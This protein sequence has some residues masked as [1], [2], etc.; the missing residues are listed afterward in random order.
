MYTVYVTDSASSERSRPWT[1]AFTLLMATVMGVAIFSRAGLGIFSRFLIEDFGISRTQLGTLA[2]V[3]ALT[4]AFASPFMGQIADRVGGKV[5]AIAVFA[6]SA[7][8][9]VGMALSPLFIVLIA[10]GMIT[11]IAQ[12]AANPST[13]KLIRHFIEPGRR[14][15]VTGFKQSGVQFA[16]FI[17]GLV[18]PTLALAYGWRVA[19]ALVAL[20]PLVGIV[21]ISIIIPRDAPATAAAGGEVKEKVPIPTSVRWIASQ[22]VLVGFGAGAL[23]TYLALY[24]EDEVGMHVTRAGFLVSVYGLAGLISRL[25]LPVVS[26]RGRHRAHQMLLVAAA[27]IVGTLLIWK[28]AEV[29]VALVWIGAAIAGTQVAWTALAML[30]VITRVPQLAAGRA[31]GFVT[32][33]FGVGLAMGPPVFGFIVDSAGYDQAFA[34]LIAVMIGAVGLMMLWLR[35]ETKTPQLVD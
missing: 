35:S 12:G 29:S 26:E 1:I 30:D 23:L 5:M 20:V 4:G 14:G 13:N 19:L 22:G 8:G 2:A 18:V 24:A 15:F 16:L 28:G 10:T 11:G 9:V 21:L 34:V 25:V 31:S 33:G 6:L 17:G 7:I 3:V 27:A 32:L